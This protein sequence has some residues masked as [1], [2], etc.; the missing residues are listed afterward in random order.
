MATIIPYVHDD[1][2]H[3][4]DV[5]AMSVALDDI[6]QRLKISDGAKA[7]KEVIA[8]RIIELARRGERSPIAL[9]DRVLEE[10]GLADGINSRSW[11]GM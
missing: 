7:A 10:S 2:F 9:R 5:K 11:S 3:P 4:N 1:E 6:C 8:G